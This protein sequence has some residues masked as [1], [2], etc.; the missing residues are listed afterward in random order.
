[1]EVELEGGCAPPGSGLAGAC[2][3]G[4]GVGASPTS[5][6]A[7]HLLPQPLESPFDYFNVREDRVPTSLPL[8]SSS[9]HGSLLLQF[10]H[11]FGLATKGVQVYPQ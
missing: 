6:G 1:M 2:L 9:P 3:F 7:G 8:H 4:F 10:P 5:T 11:S